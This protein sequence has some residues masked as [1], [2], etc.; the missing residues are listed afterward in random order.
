MENLN[1]AL[2]L[3]DRGWAVIPILS[4][5]KRP[6]VKWGHYCDTLTLPTE[7]EVTE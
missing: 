1:A 2:E 4:E 6:A 7:D 5:T 3:L